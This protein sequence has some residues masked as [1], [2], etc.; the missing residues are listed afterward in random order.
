[1]GM[2]NCDVGGFK[3]MIK[4]HTAGISIVPLDFMSVMW[5]IRIFWGRYYMFINILWDILVAHPTVHAE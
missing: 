1:M 2:L 3:D 5:R 4:L